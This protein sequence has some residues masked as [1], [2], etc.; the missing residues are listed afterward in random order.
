MPYLGSTL[1]EDPTT[2]FAVL[3]LSAV[4]LPAFSFAHVGMEPLLRRK[5]P[6]D[7]LDSRELSDQDRTLR[8]V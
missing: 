8:G 4:L 1:K 3:S 6:F 5:L 7:A 2:S